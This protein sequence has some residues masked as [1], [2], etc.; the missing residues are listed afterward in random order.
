MTVRLRLKRNPSA[1]AQRK[2][3][4]SKLRSPEVATRFQLK[5]QNRFAALDTGVDNPEELWNDFKQGITTMA[6][7][8][9]GHKRRKKKKDFL[10][11]ETLN[12][13]EAK[14]T[15]RL[16][17]NLGEYRRLNGK[18]NKLLRKDK[19]RWL[20]SLAGEAE[21]AARRSDQG[22]VYRTLRTLSGKT[23]PSTASV[24]ALDGT[25][26]DTPAQQTAR[27][28]E[29]F[30]CLLN[31]PRKWPRPYG[32]LNLA[33]PLGRWHPP[34]CLL[35][36]G[37]A[38]AAQLQRL[39]TA[40]AVWNSET[41]PEDWLQGIIL[42]FWKN[43]PKDLCSNYRGITLLSVPGKVFA[44]VV[45]G[46]LR[47][48]LLRKQRKEQSGFTPGRSTVDRILTLRLLAQKRREFRKYLFAAY[49]DLKQAFDSVDRQ[50][51]WK[52]L[53]ILGVPG[54]L[55]NLLSLLYSDTVSCVRVNGLL[56]DNFDIISGV[57]QGC[58]LAPSIFN[59]AIDYVMAGVVG[60]CGCGASYGDVT[61][62]D[63]DYADDV[64]IL[65]EAMDILQL[66]L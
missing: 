11:E 12:V 34:E 6:T 9:L 63:L 46:R 24:K 45:L 61:I 36:G 35:Y 66:A 52:I 38:V 5:L 25:V 54:K 1:N 4:I 62:T 21:A 56:S 43:G 14:R 13:V 55:L 28:R 50:A 32:N 53:R 65:A 7:K 37:P 27:W 10:S 29:H 60:Q 44:N 59:T 49:V 48:L 17:G 19:Q 3:D 47:P 39:F 22:S 58:V 30:Q 2:V 51:L 33:E 42:P 20:D 18:R 26:P 23:T 8:V 41:I 64:A 16:E 57:R 40:A 15:A 31:R